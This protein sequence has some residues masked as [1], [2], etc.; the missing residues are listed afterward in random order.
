M[1]DEHGHSVKLEKQSS[2]RENLRAP[3]Q[4]RAVDAQDEAE[5]DEQATHEERDDD[6]EKDD[7]DEDE[8]EQGAGSPRGNKRARI[9]TDGDG[10]PIKSESKGKQR[11]YMELPRD[12]DGYIPGSIVRVQ[13][14]N[15]VTYDYVEFNPGPYLNMILGP[16]GTGK[17]SIACA[18]CIG[19][20]FPTSILGRASE[21]N[22]FVKLGTDKGYVEIELKGK[23][24]QGNL[25]IRRNLSADSKGSSFSING[26]PASGKEVT[27]RIG[28]LNVQVG[29]LCSFLPQDKV[30]EFARM[31]PQE[32]LRQTEKAAG[33][34]NLSAWHD[35][36]ISSGKEASQLKEMLAGEKAQ[37]QTME[38]RNDMLKKDVERYNERKK[39]EQRIAVLEL[40]LPVKEYSEAFKR[41]QETK[42]EQ[43]RLHAE[44]QR[45]KNRNAPA[46]D[47]LEKLKKRY[48]KLNQD[49]EDKKKVARSKFEAMR[50]KYDDGDALETEVQNLMNKLDNLKKEEREIAKNI[51]ELER[52]IEKLDHDIANPPDTE[53][54]DALNAELKLNAQGQRELAA[55][56][57][58]LQDRQRTHADEVA[59]W[60]ADISNAQQG[61]NRLNDVHHQKLQ[62][63]ARWDRDCAETIEWLRQ[64]QHRFKMPIIEPAAISCTVPN[65][66]YATAVE[67]CFGATQ[68]KT[69]VAQCEEDYELL[70]HLVIDTDK[71]LGRRA[72]VPTWFRP[73]SEA[74]L[75]PPP[76]SP[77]EMAAMHFD[78]Y[79]IDYVD[80]PEGLKWYLKKE[81]QLHR[82]AIALDGS[83]VPVAQAMD[84]VSRLGPRGEGGGASFIAGMTM[85]RV[86]RSRYGKR[87]PQNSTGDIRPA[88]NFAQAS[89][90]Q[91]QM[92]RLDRQIATAREN[93]ARLDEQVKELTDFEAQIQAEGKEKKAVHDDL[94]A[95]KRAIQEIQTK[96]QRMRLNRDN[97]QTRLEELRNKPPMT[98]RRKELK[99][100][101]LV[102]CQKRAKLAR[103]YND[104][105]RA[106]IKEQ[107]DATRIG[108]QYLQTGSNISAL[109]A[110]VKQHDEEFDKTLD[111][112]TKA[113]KL[114]LAAKAESKEK[115]D[116]SKA[117]LDAADDEIRERFREM[118]QSGQVNQKS[119]EDIQTDLETQRAELSMNLNTNAS[120]IEQYERRKEEIE[121]LSQKIEQRE[122]RIAKI[123]RAIKAA[124][125]NWE[126]ALE[127]L[128]NSIGTKFSA[129]FDR[130][131]CAGEIRI[132]RDEDF[133]KWAIDILVKFRDSEKLQL[134]TG[135][136]QSGGE[137]SLTTIM[138]LM[139]LTEEARAPFSLV[140]EINQGMDARAERAVHN[141]LVE[142]TCKPDSRQYF[143]IT[144][145]LLPDL[146]YDERMKV[147]CVNNGE[148]LPEERGLGNMNNL[149]DTFLQRRSR[150]N[151]SA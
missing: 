95:R 29:N 26:Q 138:Y 53:D 70:N 91:E 149:I 82:T 65:K 6:D 33:N 89:V 18:L 34:E 16:N 72:R 114:F 31:S 147:L 80:C 59:K 68:M 125:D 93:L 116:I 17:S 108:L 64:N 54:I 67:A 2:K 146:R 3:T 27:S 66:A 122:R 131:G 142:V 150:S 110:L 52:K 101:I 115:L 40:I 128:V 37:L 106:A 4:R 9:N 76:L 102:N 109:E 7:D 117:R 49:R 13:L 120:V 21:L 85:N 136:R 71:A 28:D 63:L 25:T 96:L 123:E 130:I 143:L 42:A 86:A 118:E 24:G 112:Y 73:H 60:K 57:S 69:F 77:E 12:D 87:L 81:M 36:L 50:K 55:K 41:Y 23:K 11:E 126:P 111:E 74:S 79:A 113:E 133:E 78:G 148:W 103:E 32:L 1:A 98:E 100:K 22:S 92:R 105:A 58:Q 39:I 30:A 61:I 107:S 134:L 141:E 62:A 145:K 8:D 135:Q 35:T 94:V 84:L 5:Q 129:A 47:L 44:V 19:L 151:A 45:L 43:R 88:R 46:H 140:D 14:H 90:D 75:V 104:L 56:Q 139:S 99:Q 137:R 83:K 127:R 121:S 144:P 124:Q 10:R 20:N 97:A 48:K 15:F 119:V 132:S 38:E 51:A